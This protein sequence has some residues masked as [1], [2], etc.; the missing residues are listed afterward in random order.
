MYQPEYFYIS[1]GSDARSPLRHATLH[2]VPAPCMLSAF[3]GATKKPT[4]I[5]T[6][7]P[8]VALPCALV[9]ATDLLERIAVEP[10]AGV[11]AEL[12]LVDVVLLEESGPVFLLLAFRRGDVVGGIQP[13]DVEDLERTPR[14]AGAN[15]PCLVH[16]LWFSDPV[17]DQQTRCVEERHQ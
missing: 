10:F 9:H 6:I 11:D 7:A 4:T 2:R 5:T 12:P 13:N 8:N 15:A 14:R 3:H 16:G 1:E 17:R